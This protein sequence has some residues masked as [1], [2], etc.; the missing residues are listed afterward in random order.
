MDDH[1]L[2]CEFVTAINGFEATSC[3]TTEAQPPLNLCGSLMRN[4]L[5]RISMWVLG[6]SAL[7]GNMVVILWRVFGEKKNEK[8]SHTFFVMNLAISD[9]MMGVYM[10]IIAIADLNF[11]EN[12]SREANEWRSS[13]LCKTAGAISV[14]S[15]EASVFFV[16][17]ISIDSFFS[18]VFPFSKVKL[19]KTSSNV[20]VSLIWVISVGLSVGPTVATG[21]DS[22]VYGLSDVCIGL[23][24]LTKPTSYVVEESSV[25]SSLGADSISIPVGKGKQP[26]WIY[27]IVLFLGVNLVCF[28]V[29]LACY[30]AIFVTV[31]R[32]GSKIRQSSHRDREIKLAIRMATIVGTDFACWMPVI[33]M[34]ILSQTGMV[35]ISPDM[36]AWTVVFILP[37]NSALNPYLYTFNAKLASRKQAKAKAIQTPATDQSN[38]S[39]SN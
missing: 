17:L 29:I 37:I 26:A 36:Y 11:G 2:C 21:E 22:E 27:S 1:R 34:G 39:K 10:L 20:I 9:L 33:I 3:V 4:H 14:L 13:A 35:D 19:G 16:T 5:L 38:V 24:L 7:F 30:V 28:V 6:V 15:S 31:R 25:D 23:P 18:I 8:W 12:Y 32:T